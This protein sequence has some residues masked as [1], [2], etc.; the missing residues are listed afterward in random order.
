MVRA[1][2]AFLL[3]ALLVAPGTAA[4]QRRWERQVRD[5]IKRA[6]RILEDRGYELSHEA[7]TGSLNNRDSESLTLTLREG[8]S[9]ALVAVCDEDCSDIDLRLFDPDGDEVDSDVQTDDTPIVQAAPRNTGKYRV[10]V[11]MA[12]CSTSP[13]F[14]GVGVFSK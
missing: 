9:Y 14:Y 8:S 6:G 13:C 10:K 5:Q 1:A 2:V 12:S 3:G 11:I 4:A 7:Y